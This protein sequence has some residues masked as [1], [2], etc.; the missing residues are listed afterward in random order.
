MQQYVGEYVT[1]PVSFSGAAFLDIS[2]IVKAQQE[3][4]NSIKNQGF[5]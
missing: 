3:Q 1:F 2:G 4:G 5:Y